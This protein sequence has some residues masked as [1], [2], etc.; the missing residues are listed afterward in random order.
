MNELPCGKCRNF[1][2][3]LRGTEPTRRAWCAKLSV[4]P[5][6]DRPGKLVPKGAQ[7]AAKGEPSKPYIVRADE[8]KAACQHVK[9]ADYD[10]AEYKKNRLFPPDKDRVITP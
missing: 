8:V 5:H 7:R 3:I 2:C 1:D 9:E 6:H 10:P 4:Y